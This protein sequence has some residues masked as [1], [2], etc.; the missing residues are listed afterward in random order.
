MLLD[1]MVLDEATKERLLG[2]N[3]V[4]FLGVPLERFL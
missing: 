2:M 3:A 4:E 1:H